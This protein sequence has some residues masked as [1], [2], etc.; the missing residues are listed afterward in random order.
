M[1]GYRTTFAALALALSALAAPGCAL[2]TNADESTEARDIDGPGSDVDLSV[3]FLNKCAL[4]CMDVND[5]CISS[6]KMPQ[7]C[8]SLEDKCL[9]NY[10]RLRQS[11]PKACEGV[12]TYG[13]S[14]PA[15]SQPVLKRL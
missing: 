4:S 13:G 9:C 15:T 6:G 10:C 8:D 3:D 5:K 14:L 12:P 7:Y 2:D 1:N 11:D